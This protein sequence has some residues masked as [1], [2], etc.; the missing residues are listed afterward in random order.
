MNSELLKDFIKL[1]FDLMDAVSDYLPNCVKKDVEEIQRSFIE[2]AQ[3]HIQMKAKDEQSKEAT[4]I[5]I[6]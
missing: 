2:A 5:P 6:E 3:T 4:E 1:H